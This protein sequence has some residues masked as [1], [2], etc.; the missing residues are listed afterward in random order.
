[1]PL[2]EPKNTLWEIDVEQIDCDVAHELLRQAE[3]RQEAIFRAALGMDQRAAVLAA[4][5]AAAAGAVTAAGL[6]LG[7]DRAALHAAAFAGAALAAVASALC[8]WVCRPQRFRFPGLEPLDWA[9]SPEYLQEKLR[10]L[11]VA[12]AAQLQDHMVANERQQAANGRFLIAGMLTAAAAAPIA[13][14]TFFAAMAFFG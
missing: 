6:T 5:F 1:M 10:D 3:L 9:A 2:D 7:P 12:R 13:I 11:I 14:V 4:G 8:A